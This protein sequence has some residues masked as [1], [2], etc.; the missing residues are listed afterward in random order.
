MDPGTLEFM[1]RAIALK[2]Q[3]RRGWQRVGIKRPESVA[4][5]SWGVALLALAAA[6]ERPHLDRARLLELAITH[7]L[8][9]AI[10]GDLIPGEYAHKGEKI[11]RERRALEDLVDTLPLPLRSRLLARFE[12]LASDATPE[13]HLVHQLDKLEM[14]LQAERYHSQGRAP[15]RDLDAFHESA[16]AGISDATLADAA[17]RLRRK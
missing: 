2:D 5:H 10:L 16:A 7:D 11:A 17:R 4:D 8:A 1:R 12:E 3:M 15:G 6:E 13:A 9:E 14:A